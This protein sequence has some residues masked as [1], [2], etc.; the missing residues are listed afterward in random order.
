MNHIININ[1]AGRLAT[2]FTDRL[3]LGR[4]G[5]LEVTRASHVEFNG[6]TQEWEV[7]WANEPDTVVFSNVS[8]AAC[9]AWEVE[10]L[11]KVPFPQR[12]EQVL[13]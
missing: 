7:A 8:R 5:K 3:P 11:G 13:I 1:P 2:I 12:A 6:D 10:Q 9:I 4:L